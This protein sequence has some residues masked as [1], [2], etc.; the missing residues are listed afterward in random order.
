MRAAVGIAHVDLD[1]RW[2][3]VNQRLCEIVGYAREDLREQALQD[4]THPDDRA[5][6][7]ARFDALARGQ[8]IRYSVVS[9][10]RF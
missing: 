7:K 5:A 10:E 1:G 4:L 2:L 8:V 6:H 3:L 9:A